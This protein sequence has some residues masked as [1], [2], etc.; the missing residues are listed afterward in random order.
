MSM[1]SRRKQRSTLKRY[2]YGFS[3]GSEFNLLSA[4]KRQAYWADIY[5]MGARWVRIDASWTTIQYNGPAYWNWIT[6]D[7]VVAEAVAA[8]LQVLLI[9]QYAP[10]WACP[11][12][13]TG[14]LPYVFA[15]Y[16]QN[17]QDYANFVAACVQRYGPMGV[18]A[19]E[20]WNEP[21]NSYFW[22]DSPAS[23][24]PNAERYVQLLQRAYIAA[25]NSNPACVIITGGM[26]SGDGTDPRFIPAR[27]YLSQIY[28]HGGK[29]YFDAVGHHPYSYPTV[30][31]DP[32][33]WSNWTIMNESS[34]S[35]RSIMTTHGD[36][37]KKI[38]MTETGA[39]TSGVGAVTEAIQSQNN[40]ESVVRNASYDWAGPVFIWTYRDTAAYSATAD[41]A[42]YWGVYKQDDTPKPSVA[43]LKNLI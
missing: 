18:L 19:Y 30:P 10:P 31:S 40:L 28:Q 16:D 15:P 12:D 13:T 26:A 39:P 8:K 38:W 21:N 3:I 4:S 33:P 41:N 14:T 23:P 27:D 35:L 9:P 34:P 22:A 29:N 42:P 6:L 2:R 24:Y 17:F 20:I 1:A 43:A 37:A 5:A 25:K 7:A 36:A 32:Q 11:Q